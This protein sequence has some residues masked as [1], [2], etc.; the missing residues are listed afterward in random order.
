[1]KDFLLGYL[2]LGLIVLLIVP[3]VGAFLLGLLFPFI[4]AVLFV[5]ETVRILTIPLRR[6]G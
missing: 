6:R 3:P 4:L 2:V 1:M 5:T